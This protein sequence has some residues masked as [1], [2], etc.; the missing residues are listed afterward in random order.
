VPSNVLKVVGVDVAVYGEVQ[1]G[2]EGC[3]YVGVKDRENGLYVKIVLQNDYIVG[4]IVIG[5]KKLQNRL[6]K[7]VEK[8]K[9]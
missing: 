4:A 2:I 9:Q 6:G 3:T 8:N 7:L 5:N 1:D